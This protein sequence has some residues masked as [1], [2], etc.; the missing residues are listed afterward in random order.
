MTVPQHHSISI[1]HDC[2]PGAVHQRQSILCL[3]SKSVLEELLHTLPTQQH[4]AMAS[5]AN[6]PWV[7]SPAYL[8]SSFSLATGV[9]GFL[10]CWLLYTPTTSQ[11]I[12]GPT[13]LDN[14][15]YCCSGIK[16]ADQT[17][18]L[19]QSQYTDTRPIS[20]RTDPITPDAWQ[21]SKLAVSP[22]RQRV[23]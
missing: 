7:W 22:H 21:G 10:L 1:S 20:S 15:T 17:C 8:F 4:V 23:V 6:N 16:A 18:Y 5:T 12:H 11:C 9:R 2:T 14:C 3:T 13:C 19:T